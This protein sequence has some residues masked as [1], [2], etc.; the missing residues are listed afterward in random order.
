MIRYFL[1]VL[2][3]VLLLLSALLSLSCNGSETATPAPTATTT[4]TAPGPTPTPAD[5]PAPG[6]SKLGDTV[7]VHYTGTLDDGTEFESSVGGHP[8]AFVIGGG[9]VIQGF[10]QATLGMH[11][12]ENKTV[13]IPADQ[14]YGPYT[15]SR[16]ELP[17]GFEPEIGKQ[18]PGTTLTIVDVSESSVTLEDASNPLSGKALT[19]EI[20]LVKILTYSEPPPMTID[21]SKQ[22]TA[23]IQTE[24]GNLVLELFAA[25]APMTVN[26]FVFLA[27]DGFYDG[28]Y[29]HRVK[30]G[31]MAQ[32][33]DPIGT[34]SGGP[35]YT[36]ADEFS[37]ERGHGVGTVSMA[38]SGPD[39]NGSQ[40]F[41]T[42][43][44]QSHLDNVHSVFGQLI[45][46][47]DVLESLVNGDVMTRV[48][49]AEEG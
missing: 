46:G 10:E 3:S 22:Y 24:K 13:T 16:D 11:P 19:F 45:E 41:I 8:Y 38:N 6:Q 2:V 29:F 30:P 47:M 31:F 12:G 37:D 17:E 43:A 1:T 40:F 7:R 20:E 5:T 35:G 32:G 14:A 42:Y 49:I 21:P 26:N 15:A 39:T 44:P 28:V 36:F 33:G 4:P 27:R 9:M 48:T 34:G 18:V 23:T 25:D